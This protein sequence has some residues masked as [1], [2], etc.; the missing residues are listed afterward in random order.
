MTH[1]SGSYEDGIYH[2]GVE[3]FFP[4]SESQSVRNDYNNDKTYEIVPYTPH[5]SVS[6]HAPTP[7]SNFVQIPPVS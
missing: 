3:R 1:P 4:S 5:P 7:K 2:F 6:Y